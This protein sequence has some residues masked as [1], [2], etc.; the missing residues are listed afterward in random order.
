MPTLEPP[1]DRR[2][3]LRVFSTALS[4]KE[5]RVYGVVDLLTAFFNVRQFVKLHL[6]TFV[7]GADLCRFYAMLASHC[8]YRIQS[9]FHPVMAGRIHV[10][11]FAIAIQ[12]IGGFVNL[13]RSAVQ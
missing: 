12:S 10:Q 5:R 4:A 6:Q 7:N 8:G 3:G 1:D 13:N 11:G 2:R 9:L